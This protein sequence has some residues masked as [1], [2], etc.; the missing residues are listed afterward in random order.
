MFHISDLQ[1]KVAVGKQF[2]CRFQKLLRPTIHFAHFLCVVKFMHIF[3][4]WKQEARGKG[5][6]SVEEG[7]PGLEEEGVGWEKGED[8]GTKRLGCSWKHGGAAEGGEW[9]ERGEE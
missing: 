4:F 5:Q 9:W 8:K 6:G 7:R 3:T 2:S 1:E